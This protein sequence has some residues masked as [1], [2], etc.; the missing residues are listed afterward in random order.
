VASTVALSLSLHVKISHRRN[1]VFFQLLSKVHCILA[2]IYIYIYTY[3]Y[4]YVSVYFLRNWWSLIE[5]YCLYIWS[6]PTAK[7]ICISIFVDVLNMHGTCHKFK[8][9]TNH[10]SVVSVLTSLDILYRLWWWPFFDLQAKTHMS[11]SSTLLCLLRPALWPRYVNV[12][13][14]AGEGV[15]SL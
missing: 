5:R 14:N 2:Y 8:K 13:V 9:R 4:I 11:P 6:A 1:S 15:V 3:I 7:S 12:F 10:L